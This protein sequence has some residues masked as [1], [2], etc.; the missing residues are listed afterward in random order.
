MLGSI[1]GSSSFGKLLPSGTGCCFASGTQCFYCLG[2]GHL[3]FGV[4]SLEVCGRVMSKI[5]HMLLHRCAT[6]IP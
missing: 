6:Q 5:T 1:L 2:S 3:Q 4:L